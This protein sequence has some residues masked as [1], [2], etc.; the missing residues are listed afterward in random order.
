[1]VPRARDAPACRIAT[2]AFWLNGRRGQGWLKHY[3]WI[4][5]RFV[6]NAM[7]SS[8]FALRPK[9]HRAHR[10]FR[11]SPLFAYRLLMYQ[12]SPLW[13]ES[14]IDAFYAQFHFVFDG[15][16]IMRMYRSCQRRS[17]VII[18]QAAYNIAFIYHIHAIFWSRT[19]RSPVKYR[20]YFEDFN[21]G[22]PFGTNLISLRSHYGT[23]N[24]LTEKNTTRQNSYAHI[25]AWI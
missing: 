3:R 21:D 18:K 16:S 5:H 7:M 1:M 2:A 8:I 24:T 25:R 11:L 10:S 23:R 13:C 14:I 17:L 15:L 6:H 22:V 9:R 19:F 12:L 20:D 4:F